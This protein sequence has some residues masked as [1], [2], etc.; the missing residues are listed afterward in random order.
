MIPI[1]EEREFVSSRAEESIEFGISSKDS[2][3]IMSILRDQL[4][5]DKIMAVLRE[6]GANAQDANAMAGRAHIPI[7]VSMPTLADP[8]LRIRD[9]GP[10]QSL[11]DVRTVFSQYGA[12]TKRD[13]NEAV[14]MLGIG[15]KSPFAYSDSFM[16]IS[17]HDGTKAVY[18]AVIDPS[19]RGQIDLLDASLCDPD[20][21]GV[22]VQ[23]AVRPADCKA[24]E[25]RARLLYVHFTP[26]PIIDIRLDP[27]PQ[28]VVHVTGGTV[29]DDETPYAV[30]GKWIAVMGCIPYEINLAQLRT[31]TDGG[32]LSKACHSVS[33]TLR[34]GIGELQVAASRESLKYGDATRALLIDRI[35]AAIDE[36][37]DQML[38][39]ID[40]LSNWEKRLRVLKIS[41]RNLPI[42]ARLKRFDE[43]SVHLEPDSH[44]P[45][46]PSLKAMPFTIQVRQY[47]N[48]R[49]TDIGSIIP[50]RD[51]RLIIVDERRAMGGYDLNAQSYVVK[52]AKLRENDPKVWK[53]LDSFR[54]ALEI[55]GIQTCKLSSI[56]WTKPNS[57]SDPRPRD[58]TKA[59]SRRFVLDM[60]AV[61]APFDAPSDVWKPE[62][63]SPAASDVF[64]VI[65]SYRARDHENFFDQVGE[66]FTLCSQFGLSFP[67]IIGYKS[68]KAAPVRT[69]D[70]TGTE[71]GAWRK[72]GLI[73][74]LM[75]HPPVKAAV[76]ALGFTT[77][78]GWFHGTD[79]SWLVQELGKSHE[80]AD[81]ALNERRGMMTLQKTGPAVKLAAS[82][83]RGMK[84][85][86][87]WDEESDR[88]RKAIV[89]KYP[90]L[91]A[92]PS[93]ALA[94]GD[95]RL[96]LD[97]IKLI[98][99]IG[100]TDKQQE[101]A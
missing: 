35:N 68:T 61:R 95:K 23:M 6:I 86:I 69:A 65:E 46:R 96:W 21:T 99:S 54:V 50:C 78:C 101:K 19:G 17:R 11:D 4:Y 92:A 72:T 28:N 39:G 70:L 66:D 38:T 79:T 84:P 43:H 62:V 2:V 14:G 9:H 1:R 8:T 31:G 87:L 55:D 80:M 16:V 73:E 74:I 88:A 47:N 63:E 13:S 26:R 76:V 82:W 57:A 45:H 34:F 97:Y 59:K 37:V 89:G 25:D 90:L 15:S 100:S 83:I 52:P 81:Y 36:F 64:V 91:G 27:P 75:T 60:D 71:Y 93:G 53:E 48:G 18:N 33:A 94:M 30:H 85:A 12:S 77:G 51:A 3:H 32:R 56:K 5:S 44:R 42:P 49:M 22:E 7:E 58:A 29:N 41:R 67:P 20:D 24:F 98:D 40:S 10:G